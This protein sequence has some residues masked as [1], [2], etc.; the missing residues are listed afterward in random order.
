MRKL[1]G[2]LYLSR[3]EA[4]PALPHTLSTRTLKMSSSD[5]NSSSASDTLGSPV[6]GA[7][8]AGISQSA[9]RFFFQTV[10]LSKG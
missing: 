7:G 6:G 1:V 4:N 5:G 9:F 10:K 2:D 3:F 8:A